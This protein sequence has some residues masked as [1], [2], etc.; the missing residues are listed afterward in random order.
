M[1]VEDI[2]LDPIFVIEEF[3]PKRVIGDRQNPFSYYDDEEFERRF[4]LPKPIIVDLI[5][6]IYE[7]SSQNDDETRGK[8]LYY[9]ILYA[10]I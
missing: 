9:S 1:E 3:V 7:S 10:F 8:R 2:F 4:R 6:E 5:N